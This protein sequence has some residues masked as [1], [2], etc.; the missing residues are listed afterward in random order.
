MGSILN[1]MWQW[2]DTSSYTDHLAHIS[3]HVYIQCHR[4][5]CPR[6]PMPHH[7]T[8][9]KLQSSKNLNVKSIP[10]TLLDM[11]QTPN[12]SQSSRS[13]NVQ[14]MP[15]TKQLT[16]EI[17]IN[18][19]GIAIITVTFFWQMG[20]THKAHELAYSTQVSLHGWRD[21]STNSKTFPPWQT[22]RSEQPQEELGKNWG[23][24]KRTHQTFQHVPYCKQ[25]GLRR[26]D[27]HWGK[28]ETQQKDTTAWTSKHNVSWS[29]LFLLCVF[30]KWCLMLWCFI[31]PGW[32]PI[33]QGWGTHA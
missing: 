19:A 29:Q 24:K 17:T 20:E 2:H 5:W 18:E 30:L 11:P 7:Q 9:N 4:L 27:K 1:W 25:Q 16:C 3:L 32:C 33:A 22:A 15:Q 8:Q 28:T 21:T 13:L 12:M 10:K 23:P 26:D 31:S 14:S 6:H